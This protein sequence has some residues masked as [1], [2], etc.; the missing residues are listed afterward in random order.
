MWGAAHFGLL[1]I[2][3][4]PEPTAAERLVGEL[5]PYDH[6]AVRETFAF[7]IPVAPGPKDDVGIRV[8]RRQ[9]KPARSPGTQR[10]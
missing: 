3:D 10:T 9:L 6:A 2:K 8:L 1:S 5:E 7:D 4:E